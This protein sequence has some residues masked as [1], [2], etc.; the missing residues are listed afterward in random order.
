MAGA[1]Y[2][3]KVRGPQDLF[4]TGKPVYSFIKQVYKRHVNF[5]TQLIEIQSKNT[6][7]FG[8]TIEFNIPR[9]ADYLHKVSFTFTLP[10]LSTTSGSYAGWTNSIGHAIIDYIEVSIGDQVI[11]HHT[12]LYLEI[13]NELTHTN[14]YNNSNATLLGKYPHIKALESN[15]L[16]ETVYEV[17]LQF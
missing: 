11:T 1:I 16:I 4:L 8:K 9:K 14:V 12:G 3:L 13:L 5:A 7:D 17:P 2:Q 6:V 15:A 10:A